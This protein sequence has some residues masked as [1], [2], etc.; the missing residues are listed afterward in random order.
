M[1]I[2]KKK[3][4]TEY[5][6]R[7]SLGQFFTS[8]SLVDFIT[9][10]FNIDYSNKDILEPSFGGCAFVK[11]ILAN[12]I[13]P[14]I[15]GVD[16][17]KKLCKESSKIYP[18]VKFVCNDF[19]AFNTAKKF[20]IIIGNPPFN[21]DTSFDYYDSTEGFV[22]HSI[23][24]LGEGG[25]LFFVLPATVLRNKQYQKLRHFILSNTEIMGIINTS[26][27]DFLGAD[28]ETIVIG[29]K[30]NRVSSQK[31]FYI[32]G[33]QRRE[34]IGTQNQRETILI[35]NTVIFNSVSSKLSN[36]K[37]GDLFD[38]YRGHSKRDEA[39]R[40]RDI[41]FYGYFLKKVTSDSKYCI[42]V[43]NI[44]YRLTSNL[45]LVDKEDVSDTVTLLVPKQKMDVFELGYY[46]EFLNSAIANYL[47]HINALNECRLTIH[48][49]KYYIEDISLPLFNGH[50]DYFIRVNKLIN[51]KDFAIFRDDY[52]DKI[53]G[54][55]NEEK[56]DVQRI[57]TYPNIRIKNKYVLKAEEIE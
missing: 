30:R 36:V 45:F 4:T 11:Y 21:L 31:Y 37:I 46:S 14:K 56:D 28:I 12:S 54:L 10:T 20:D 16:I 23:D 34:V 51:K 1:N 43:Q 49:D 44:A 8:D 2:N 29:L 27:Y 22:K 3:T 55:S 48:I 53:V 50:D 5:K 32:N 57:W 17:D 33:N 40:G 6:Q 24:L 9:K 13:R 47:L 52:F 35:N 7:H 38:I 19:L 25:Y 39:V 41:N 26:K 15:V 42:G 18:D